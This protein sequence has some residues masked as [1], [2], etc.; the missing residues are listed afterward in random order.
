MFY[1]VL[2]FSFKKNHLQEEDPSFSFLKPIILIILIF[3]FKFKHC[4]HGKLLNPSDRLTFF[5]T[6]SLMTG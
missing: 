2:N 5:F 1:C 4:T 6:I 3:Y